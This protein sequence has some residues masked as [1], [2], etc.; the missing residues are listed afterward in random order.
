MKIYISSVYVDDQQKALEFYTETLGFV[1]KMDIPLGEYRWLT[2]VSK[3]DQ[4]GTEL[5][6]EPSAHPAVA[7]YRE[8]LVSDGIPLASFQV[9][10]LDKEYQ[11]LFGAGVKFTQ[12]PVDAA[13]VKMAVLEDTCGNLIQIVELQGE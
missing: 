12:P 13:D 8:A 11:R 7:P 3:D 6:L 1:K 5:L 4:N 10:N 9:D 2:V